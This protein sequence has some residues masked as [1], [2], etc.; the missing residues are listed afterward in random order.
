MTI[1][2]RKIK[3]KN[4]YYSSLSYF[5]ISGSR[6]FSK[7]IGRKL[8]GDKEV[9][10]VENSFKEELIIRLF[11]KKCANLTLS[12]DEVIR[13]LLFSQLF[14]KK[15]QSLNEFKRRKY[16]IDSTVSFTL[17][18]LTTEEVDVELS[19][20][21]N[22]LTNA[23]PLTPKEKISKN[24][25]KA[26]ESI[27]QERTLD[28]KYL[29]Q[30]H[31]T[32]M[33]SFEAKNPGHFRN[34]TVYL[35]RRNEYDVSSGM[36]ISYRPPAYNNIEDL[37]E[38]FLKWYNSTTLNPIEKAALAHYKLYRIHPFL[39]GNKRICRLV[40]NK[41]LLEN[42]FPLINISFEK[43]AY[44]DALVE[45][46]ENDAPIVFVEFALKQYYLQVREFLQG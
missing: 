22:A 26:I 41:A 31:K 17:T 34:R 43:D 42:K 3:G 25:L 6:S 33:A 13:A 24:M 40:F 44:F 27:S 15:Y 11:G 29:L 9:K 14:N 16:D 36:E 30:L 18:T 21:K 7:Y 35:K 8:P 46:V 45:S 10:N 12:K 38:E 2:A 32:I 23:S 5:L 19:D 28:K 4:Y 37:I 39:D 20:V 1:V